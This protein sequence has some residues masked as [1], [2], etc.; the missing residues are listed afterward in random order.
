MNVFEYRL[1]S[2]EQ[3]PHGFVAQ[4]NGM[5]QEGKRSGRSTAWTRTPA[6]ATAAGGCGT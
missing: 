1:L 2:V 6:P 4:L 5:G 3:G